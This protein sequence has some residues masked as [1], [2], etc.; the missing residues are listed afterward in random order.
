MES[1]FFEDEVYFFAVD[2]VG[3]VAVGDGVGD[4]H[5]AEGSVGVKGI[6]FAVARVGAVELSCCAERREQND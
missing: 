4:L 1:A 5:P 2:V 6:G 3:T